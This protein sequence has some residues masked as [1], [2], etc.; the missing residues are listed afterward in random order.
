MI[1]CVEPVVSAVVPF[2]RAGPL[3]RTSVASLLSQTLTDIEVIA[4]DFG[5]G[6]E[7]LC[8]FES[9]WRLKV[10]RA[11]RPQASIALNEGISHARGAYTAFLLEGDVAE[12]DR[13]RH[14]L[15]ILARRGVDAVLSRPTLVD[16]DGRTLCDSMAPE[17]SC[18]TT[19]ASPPQMLRRLLILGNAL[20]LSTALIRTNAFKDVGPFRNGLKLMHDYDFWMRMCACR[21]TIAVMQKRLTRYRLPARSEMTQDGLVYE[22]LDCILSA[23][24]NTPGEVL[25]E[26]FPELLTP[27]SI[28]ASAFDRAVIALSHPLSRMAG[29]LALL[30][31]F[32][33]SPS[34]PDDSELRD[35]FRFCA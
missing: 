1:T 14:Q 7:A 28:A 2:R 31:S 10:I 24:R 11:S 33:G 26:S 21:K 6:E 30:Q 9:D 16:E 25:A 17:F 35:L 22:K 19:R 27:G 20:C 18:D 13:M 3:V 34:R 8:E 32:Y 4:V 5:D 23:I 29:N 12:T 15:E